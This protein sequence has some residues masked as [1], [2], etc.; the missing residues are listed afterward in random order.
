MASVA[1]VHYKVWLFDDYRAGFNSVEESQVGT[2]LYPCYRMHAGDRS[3]PETE[4]FLLG[5]QTNAAG[6]DFDYRAVQSLFNG[7][8]EDDD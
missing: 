7:N 2:G 4:A 6:H 8:D 3:R 1:A 5:C